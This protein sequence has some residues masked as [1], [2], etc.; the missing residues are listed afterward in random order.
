MPTERTKLRNSNLRQNIEIFMFSRVLIISVLLGA[1]VIFQYSE[2]GL[3]VAP[4]LVYLYS[5]I[6]LTYFLTAI[7][8]LLI[9]FAEKYLTAIA[10]L[11]LFFDVLIITGMVF[12]T[13]AVE[14]IFS[15]LYILSIISASIILYRP[16]G[17][18]TASLSGILYGVMVDLDYYGLIPTIIAGIHP[19]YNESYVFYN[20]FINIVAFYIVAFLSGYL[21]EQVKKTGE[22]LIEKRI[23]FEE[24]K[25][26]NNNIIQ[27]IQTGLITIDRQGRIISF[28]RQAEIITGRSLREVYRSHI[29][30]VIPGILIDVEESEASQASG[31]LN[32]WTREFVSNN[33]KRYFLGFSVSPFRN[34][35][36]QQVGR[37]ILFLDITHIRE[38][39]EEIKRNDTLANLGKFAAN[40]AHEIRNPLGSMSGSIQLLRKELSLSGSNR[41]LM[42]IVL[43]EIERLNHLITNFLM[44]ARPLTVKKEPVDLK[45]VIDE[46]IA[47]FKNT[48]KGSVDINITTEFSGNTMIAGDFMQLKQVFWNLLLNAADAMSAGGHIAIKTTETLSAKDGVVSVSVSDSGTGIEDEIKPLI[49]D[50]FFSTK[51]GGTGLGLPTVK[52]IIEAHGGSMDITSQKG[53]G[54]DVTVTLP[55][56]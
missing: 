53:K 9:K 7:Y 2:K 38:M 52:L 17:F 40:L 50:P 35:Q 21:S 3:F 11:Q 54:T 22:E 36:N 18:L 8:I 45:K 23:D 5:L 15:F 48:P 27:N 32:R 56:K 41:D 20:I 4:Q 28:N 39:E 30:E 46:T 44:Y 19:N 6:G 13:G 25:I 43:K 49:F 31:G 42:D 33:G 51:D 16:G 24:L 12:I 34:S 29:D 47:V 26:L 55:G 1:S 37:I 14:S 10:Y